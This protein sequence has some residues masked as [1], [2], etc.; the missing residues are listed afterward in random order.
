MCMIDEIIKQLNMSSDKRVEYV[1]VG[2]VRYKFLRTP[3]GYV[4]DKG[5]WQWQI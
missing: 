2:R 3:S 1:L 4:L 5:E